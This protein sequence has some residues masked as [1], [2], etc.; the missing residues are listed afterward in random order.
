MVGFWWIVTAI[1]ENRGLAH[2]LSVGLPHL[3]KDFQYFRTA[4]CSDDSFATS[5]ILFSIADEALWDSAI[6]NIPP[7]V[8]MYD[9]PRCATRHSSL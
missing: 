5:A 1:I 9:A 8:Q 4:A 7:D 2:F 3:F 6:K